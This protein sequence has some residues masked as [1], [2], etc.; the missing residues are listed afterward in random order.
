MLLRV[1]K[2]HF[3][4]IDI[5]TCKATKKMAKKGHFTTSIPVDPYFL[6]LN[7]ILEF[8]KNSL[9]KSWSIGTKIASQHSSLVISH[10]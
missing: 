5:T 2:W 9:R 7:Y 1:K 3:F 10:S 8:S 4:D 6:E